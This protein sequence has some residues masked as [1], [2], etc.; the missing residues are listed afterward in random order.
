MDII[1]YKINTLNQLI[2]TISSLE[3]DYFKEKKDE[4]DNKLLSYIP[5]GWEEVFISSKNELKEIYN[6]LNNVNFFPEKSKLFRV[7]DLCPLNS[8]K[9]VIL[10]QDPYHN[11]DKEGNPVAQGIAFSVEKRVN[12]PSSLGNIFKEI[13]SNIPGF[14]I[15][16]HGDLTNWIKQ[17][18]FLLNVCLTVLPGKPGSHGDLWIG[19]ISKVITSICRTNRDAIFVLWGKKAQSYKK[20]ISSKNKILEAAHPSGLSANKGFFNCNHFNLINEY[21]KDK[22]KNPINWQI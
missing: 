5:I 14:N 6:Q 19:L 20:Y 10:G 1:N 12:I 15:P 17:G 9:I 4:L 13:K 8:I 7:F 11:C 2:S 21:L 22:G 16:N 18:V 3:E